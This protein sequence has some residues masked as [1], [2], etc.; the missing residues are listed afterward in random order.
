M[1]KDVH[2][3]S[4]GRLILSFGCQ[5]E[6]GLA[7]ALACA[8]ARAEENGTNQVHFGSDKVHL[9]IAGMLILHKQNGKYPH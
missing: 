2:M 3:V 8:R 5:K 7:A 4:L 9:Q 1:E 6:P